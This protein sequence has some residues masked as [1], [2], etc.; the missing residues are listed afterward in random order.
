MKGIKIL[1]KGISPDE[2]SRIPHTVCSVDFNTSHPCPNRINRIASEI[3][4]YLTWKRK[5]KEGLE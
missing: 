4:E 1:H 2:Y 5:R 3:N